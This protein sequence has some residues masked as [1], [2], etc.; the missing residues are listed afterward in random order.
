M[1]AYCSEGPY[2]RRPSSQ[3][4]KQAVT[5]TSVTTTDDNNNVKI[6]VINMIMVVMVRINSRYPTAECVDEL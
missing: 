1:G 4:H 5:I 2:N 3:T 6:S